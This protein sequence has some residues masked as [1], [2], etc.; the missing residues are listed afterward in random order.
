[1]LKIQK[2]IKFIALVAI[3]ALIPA[4]AVAGTNSSD[5]WDYYGGYADSGT[6]HYNSTYYS[7]S[8]DYYNDY[9]PYTYSSTPSYTGS[10][11]S[12]YPTSSYTG[13]NT[14]G[15]YYPTYTGGT[16]YP[17]YN[18]TSSSVPSGSNRSNSN[19]NATAN[20]K[21]TSNSKSNSNSNAKATNNTTVTTNSNSSAVASS[22]NINNNINNNNVFVYTNPQ[23]TAVLQNPA[24][25]HLDGYCLITPNNPRVGQ[26][27]TVTAYATGGIGSYTYT[28]GGDIYYGSGASTQFTSQTAGTKNISVTVRSGEEV[29]TRNCSVTF[30][31][32]NNNNGSLTANCYASPQTA[33][34]NETITWR[35]SASGG[36]G[37]YTYSWSGS[38]NLYGTGEYLSKS[39]S[40]T[41]QKS[42]TVQ[43]YAN[44][45]TVS[46][47][48]YANINSGYFTSSSVQVNRTT[49]GTP[50]SG[51]FVQ[52]GTPVSG[53]YLNQLPATGIDLN[54]IH[55]MVA[56]LALVLTTT[57]VV[58]TRSRKQLLATY[59]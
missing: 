51:V 27:V 24:F 6:G 17:T 16:N 32:E 52:P 46:A 20:P 15:T 56:F 5:G 39:Y 2:A 36:Y 33:N 29:I 55:Y 44:G 48:C 21:S 23:G 28:W 18:Y 7:P 59:R 12:Y 53:V 49:S 31:S 30:G 41:G 54:W 42:A 14:G 50:V 58:I 34:I 26:T 13:S 43:V 22:T 47:T 4:Y 25:Q 45:Q 3:F 11:N 38:D 8:Y 40:Y 37:S 35:V 57:V 19:S 10:N 9:T 1:M